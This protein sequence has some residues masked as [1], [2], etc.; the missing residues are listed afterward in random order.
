VPVRIGDHAVAELF[1]HR[2]ELRL[3]IWR[4]GGKLMIAL[5]VLERLS[6]IFQFVERLDVQRR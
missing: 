1:A 3:V 6:V 5:R 2:L 4:L